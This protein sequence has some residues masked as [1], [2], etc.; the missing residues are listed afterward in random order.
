MITTMTI[1]IHH[2]SDIVII[3]T[4]YIYG[5]SF[6]GMSVRSKVCDWSQSFQKM[7]TLPEGRNIMLYPTKCLCLCLYARACRASAVIGF[8][9]GVRAKSERKVY[10]HHYHHNHNH[11]HHHHQKFIR[12]QCIAVFSDT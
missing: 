11:H 1:M 6:W 10:S 7:G 4:I 12:I 8:V 5:G 2:P 9:R 3:V